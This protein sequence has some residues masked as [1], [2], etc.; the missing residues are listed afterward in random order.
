M[1]TPMFYALLIPAL[2]IA[3]L[4]YWYAARRNNKAVQRRE[5]PASR[6]AHIVPLALAIMLFALPDLWRGWLSLRIL[7]FSFVTYWIGIAVLVAG[8]AFTVA[9]RRHL[10][11]NWS[12]T[13]TVKHGHELIRTGPYALVRH[14]IYTGMLVGFIGS[15]ISLGEVRGVVAVGLVIVAFLIKIR[16]EERWMTESFGDAYGRYRA[17]VKALIPFLL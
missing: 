15:A 3:W 14:P 9:A 2:W 6:A 1:E 16:L 10:G 8:L 4:I 12:G 13:V 5:S 11:G 17:E 7:P